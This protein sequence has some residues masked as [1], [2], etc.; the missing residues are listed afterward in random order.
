MKII[1]SYILKEVAGPFA[2]SLV[3]LIF[4]LLMGHILQ[5]ADYVINKGVDLFDVLKL[6]S[7]LIPYLLSLALPAAVLIGLLLAMGRLSHDNE[8]TAIRSCGISLNRIMFPLIVIGLIISLFTVYLNSNIL[9]RARFATVKIAK[10][11][12]I[13]KPTAYLEQGTR[14]DTFESYI[15]FINSIRGN[16]LKHIRIFQKQENGPTRTIIAQKGEFI[17]SPDEDS[18]VLK[19]INGTSD[20]PNKKNPQSYYKLNFKTYYL[21]LDLSEKIDRGEIGKKPK[22][23]TIHDLKAKIHKLK[24]GP[25]YQQPEVLHEITSYKTEIHN[26]ISFAFA[27]LAMIFIGFPL[28]IVARREEHSLGFLIGLGIIMVYYILQLLGKGLAQENGFPPALCMWLPNL[29]TV[30]VGIFLTR[31]KLRA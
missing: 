9:P 26:K 22:H 2:L 27:S 29:L 16:K 17:S 10:E 13:K 24:N 19:L 21:T 11:I 1:R 3:V 12:G 18:I 5:L 15:I 30:G 8:I 31:Q 28:G 23:M 4:V 20:E 25:T 14:I 7:L 6:F